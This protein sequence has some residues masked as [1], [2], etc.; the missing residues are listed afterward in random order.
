MV[1]IEA[2]HESYCEEEV[3]SSIATYR[4]WEYSSLVYVCIIL[5]YIFAKGCI[6]MCNLLPSFWSIVLQLTWFRFFEV[7]GQMFSI[8]FL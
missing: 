8:I 3:S 1:V 4:I 5:R 7:L 2:M 6:F